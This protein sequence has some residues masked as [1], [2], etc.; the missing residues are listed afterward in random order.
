MAESSIVYEIAH[1]FE[2]TH[3]VV[4]NHKSTFF[5]IV[6][7][8]GP[9]FLQPRKRV[10]WLRC[11]FCIGARS[12]PAFLARIDSAEGT[13]FGRYAVFSPQLRSLACSQPNE[14][15]Y[16]LRQLPKW[17]LGMAE[18]RLWNTFYANTLCFRTRWLAK[19]GTSQW[20]NATYIY[21]P[22]AT[23]RNATLVC[24]ALQR[25]LGNKRPVIICVLRFLNIL[26]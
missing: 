18:Q 4:F 19:I 17:R 6:A 8:F 1:H 24:L 10:Q 5:E 9:N 16:L 2:T 12:A 26:K 15:S 25:R 3:A 21:D 11:L 23:R 22:A 20:H 13:P 14:L 7:T